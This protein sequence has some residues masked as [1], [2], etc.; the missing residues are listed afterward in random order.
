[1]HPAWLVISPGGPDAGHAARP[2]RT[3][4][5]PG[6]PGAVRHVRARRR[7][8]GSSRPGARP[9]SDAA[10]LSPPGAAGGG[11]PP[12]RGDGRGIDPWGLAAILEGLHLRMD[13]AVRILVQPPVC[14]DPSRRP[15]RPRHETIEDNTAAEVPSL[16]PLSPIERPALDYSALEEAMA[17]LD[18]AVR[19][20]RGSLSSLA[21]S[22]HCPARASSD[23][24]SRGGAA[25]P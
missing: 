20:A 2:R 1:M 9:P 16:P 7:R 8:C 17:H 3:A 15:S 11:P 25:C 12:S 24:P 19:S 14:P 13:H 10:G 21:P 22:D 23:A 4:S 6:R 5:Q 18:A